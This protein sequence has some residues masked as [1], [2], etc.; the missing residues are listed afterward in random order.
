MPK[1]RVATYNIHECRGPG[2]GRLRTERPDL[3][4]RVLEQIDA[5]IIGLQ[6][7][8][9]GPGELDGHL[10]EIAAMVGYSAVP[11]A[12]LR[13]DRGD[14][15]NALLS[16]WPIARIVNHRL[17]HYRDSEPRGGLEAEIQ[18][19]DGCMRVVVTHLGLRRGARK[20]QAV[21]LLDLL[22]GESSCGPVLLLGDLN[23]WTGRGWSIRLFRSAFGRQHAPRSFP[24]WLPLLRLDRI[25]CA[26]PAKVE[27]LWAHDTPLARRASDHLPVVADV[28]LPT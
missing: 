14:Y 22:A 27:R 24:S 28:T 10:Y 25:Y 19:G 16:R 26:S 1:V 11:G 9:T 2:P 13:D 12:N 8:A 5:D 20:R 4:A 15:G 7:V 17:G 23:D 21:R 3:V 6:E 18:S